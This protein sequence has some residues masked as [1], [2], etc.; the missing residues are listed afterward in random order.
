MWGALISSRSLCS[1]VSIHTRC[2]KKKV[3]QVKKWPLCSTFI[4]ILF[5]VV[6]KKI[7][8]Q[9]FIFLFFG[10][11]AVLSLIVTK[12]LMIETKGKKDFEIAE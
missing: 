12:R 3:F 6:Q 11:I 4:L 10:T 9:G 5:P 1:E 8:N 7:E 2:S